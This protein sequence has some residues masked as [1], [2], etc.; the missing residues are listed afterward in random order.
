V[1]RPAS[2]GRR[3]SLPLLRP[4]RHDHRELVRVPNDGTNRLCYAPPRVMIPRMGKHARDAILG[5]VLALAAALMVVSTVEAPS[6]LPANLL[7]VI[8]APTGSTV[9]PPE[10]G[11]VIT[12]PRPPG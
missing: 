5:T 9:T 12:T 4:G 8:F 11:P 7:P 10:V 6:F 2:L 1:P 3:G